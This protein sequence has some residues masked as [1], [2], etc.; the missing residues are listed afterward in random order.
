MNKINFKLARDIEVYFADGSDVI[1]SE[2]TQ[3]KADSVLMYFNIGRDRFKCMLAILSK[4]KL[5]SCGFMVNDTIIN[6]LWDDDGINH[7]LEAFALK[8]PE[9]RRHI[10]FAMGK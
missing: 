8:D 10:K 6:F 2:P 5:K 7:D 4:N 3:L 1:E 9:V